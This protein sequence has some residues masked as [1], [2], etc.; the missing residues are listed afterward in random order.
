MW[1]TKMNF[2]YM[3]LL[4]EFLMLFDELDL[5]EFLF[6]CCGYV[7][8]VVWE[9]MSFS[10]EMLAFKRFWQISDYVR[11][12][13]M[14]LGWGW[15]SYF[16]V[17]MSIFKCSLYGLSVRNALAKTELKS[18]SKT[19]FYVWKRKN[20]IL[21]YWWGDMT[22]CLDEA[23]VSWSPVRVDATVSWS[24]VRVEATVYPDDATVSVLENPE[25]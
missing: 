2:C 7:R 10:C 24:P 9:K 12:W 4:T 11:F 18:D 17:E 23:T 1:R 14:I 25:T 8:R 22:V 15:L 21:L 3:R 19:R 6:S 13:K 16:N 20:A 5:V